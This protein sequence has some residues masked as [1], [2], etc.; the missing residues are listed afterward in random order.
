M[1][2]RLELHQELVDILGSNDVF[3][4]P[5]ASMFLR[6][7]CIVYS[8]PKPD[9]MHADNVKYRFL[10]QYEIIYISPNTEPDDSVAMKLLE[11]PY[12]RLVNRYTADN[13]M[14]TKIEIYI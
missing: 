12:T 1:H 6:Y 4:N 7:P 3:Y 10:F 14:H 2:T 11:L 9:V 5:P 8:A 13:L